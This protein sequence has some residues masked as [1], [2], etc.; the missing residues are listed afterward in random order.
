MPR[1][2][3]VAVDVVD[4]L[5]LGVPEGLRLHLGQVLRGVAE[6]RPDFLL[7]VEETLL[8]LA[9]ADVENVGRV[10]AAE[11]ALEPCGD[12][13]LGA[14]GEKCRPCDSSF[15]NTKASMGERTRSVDRT[16]GGGAARGLRKD[17]N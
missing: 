6:L 16:F 13:G 9:W 4:H 17:Q 3:Q 2:G 8:L 10:A 14:S 11:N 12:V 1:G 15:A 7:G 5:E